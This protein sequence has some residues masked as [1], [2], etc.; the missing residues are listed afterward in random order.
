M[1]FTVR[2]PAIGTCCWEPM[3]TKQLTEPQEASTDGTMTDNNP[4]ARR[5]TM[6]RLT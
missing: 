1:A 3:T 6:N 4:K 5:L 2:S